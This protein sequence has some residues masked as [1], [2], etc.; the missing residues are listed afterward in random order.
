MLDPIF[1]AAKHKD[2]LKHKTQ[3]NKDNLVIGNDTFTV[4]PA[5]TVQHVSKYVDITE[6]CKRADEQS[7]V[8]E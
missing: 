5:S 7:V 4:L 8:N 6:V 2:N 1:L 3:L